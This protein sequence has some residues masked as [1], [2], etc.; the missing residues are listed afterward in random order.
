MSSRNRNGR[1]HPHQRDTDDAAPILGTEISEPA[2]FETAYN[3][4]IRLTMSDNNRKDYRRRIKV[5]ISF[6]ETE[7]PE[8]YSVG[9][10][11]V[12]DQDL[13]TPS[14]Y[15]FGRHKKDLVYK[16]LNVK[17]V[18][19]FL[20]RN[21]RKADGKL[22]SNED[23][24]KYKDAIMWGSAIAGER[25]PREFYEKMDNF[26]RAYKNEHA[27]AKK[28]GEVDEMAADPIPM[29]LYKLIADWAIYENNIFVWVW[30]VAQWN[31]MARSASVDPLAFHN[32]S[33]GADS[34][35]GKYDESK[36]DKAGERLSE[37]NIYANPTNWKICFWTAFGIWCS[38]QEESLVPDERLFHMSRSKE[39]TAATKYCEQLVGIIEPY[40]QEVQN[41]MRIANF[42]PYGFRKGAAT[43]AVSG[44]TA[45]PS[46][47]SVARR[48]EWS[49]G[50]VLDVY[51][52]FGS[53]G[54]HYLGRILA[55][56]DPNDPSFAT[57]PPHWMLVNPMMDEC[58]A[59]AMRMMYGGI[60]EAYKGKPHDPSPILLRC[61]AS[62]VYHS[63]S[64]LDIM[65]NIPGH[66][67]TN[68]PLLHDRALLDHL[69][70]LV[71]IKPTPGVMTTPTGIPPH[72]GLAQQLKEVLGKV[73]SLVACFENQTRSVV[74][75]IDDA[76]ENKSLE[77]G[78]V[79]GNRLKEI[80]DGFQKESV[81][82]MNEK[83]DGLREEFSA[84]RG[85]S[86]LS[87]GQERQR[88]APATTN[89]I[90]NIFTYD[91]RFFAVPQSFN[92][93]KAKLK[94]GLRLWF[95]GQSI[96]ADG[97]KRIRPYRQI[98]LALLP[99]KLKDQFKL[100]FSPIYTY[101]EKNAPSE[102]L[103]VQSSIEDIDKCY[104]TSVDFPK[105]RRVSYCFQG[106][107]NPLEWSVATWSNCTRRSSIEKHGTEKDKEYL[108]AASWRNQP[109]TTKSRKREVAAKPLYPKRQ[110]RKMGAAANTSTMTTAMRGRWITTT[111]TQADTTSTTTTT[112][113]QVV[114]TPTT[115]PAQVA[116]ATT[117]TIGTST[118]VPVSKELGRCSIRGCTFTHFAPDH[119]CYGCKTAGV[120][121]LCAQNKVEGVDL[122]Q[123][124][125]EANMFC[126]MACKQNDCM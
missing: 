50:S 123:P 11:D 34:I 97:S 41:H 102:A 46:I 2:G 88:A 63:E 84:S 80:L 36:S 59:K 103:S 48:G 6:W 94:E 96:S 118:K 95:R 77:S 72:V 19:H 99:K 117:T 109:K 92:F 67:F 108:E 86:S 17:Y 14:K 110:R 106:D 60:I 15:Y 82:A 35:I 12:L 101:L 18:L 7:V 124:G 93:P 25:L 30:T 98:K 57:L 52:H 56:L 53:V 31:F 5:I 71:T 68:M 85:Q 54:D 23:L 16:G 47:P 119:R 51:W 55:G 105:R 49:I 38:L 111:A 114:A 64:L 58:V 113:A 26:Q 125:N 13:H 122:L 37:K 74:A 4:T 43:Y 32:F 20:L 28:R 70:A 22:K 75:A 21:K 9:V 90:T 69:Q 40:T 116:T 100:H 45:A 33:L 107:R 39:G 78:Q 73:S 79:T 44:T 89:T 62:I 1:I 42:N 91:G 87:G 104:K 8:Y 24:R 27:Q 66:A 112:T 83:L 29:S 121:N 61:L 126:S 81:K 120:H 10:I 3:E 76:I 115:A 65:E